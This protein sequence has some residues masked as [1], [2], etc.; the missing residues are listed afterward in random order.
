MS[1]HKN[2]LRCHG[3]PASIIV[4]E[5]IGYKGEVVYQVT[6]G[7]FGRTGERETQQNSARKNAT[8][9]TSISPDSLIASVRV[10]CDGQGVRGV[11]STGSPSREPNDV[12]RVSFHKCQFGVEAMITMNITLTAKYSVWNHL[13][14]PTGRGTPT[15]SLTEKRLP[16][17][18]L[19]PRNECS[20]NVNVVLHSCINTEHERFKIRDPQS[21]IWC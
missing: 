18:C 7:R 8:G 4:V 15:S 1:F 9:L 6:Q 20:E 21:H 14:A 11:E 13:L 17:V 2:L 3:P 12:V 5:F 16:V 19:Q 10:W